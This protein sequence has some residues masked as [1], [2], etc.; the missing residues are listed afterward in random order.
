M[1]R[2]ILYTYVWNHFRPIV[3]LNENLYEYW[4]SSLGKNLVDSRNRLKLTHALNLVFIKRNYALL[5]LLDHL[6]FH[7]RSNSISD[8]SYVLQGFQT[9]HLVWNSHRW[10]TGLLT[11]CSFYKST[12]LWDSHLNIF[13]VM[14]SKTNIS[15]WMA[16]SFFS[17][18]LYNLHSECKYSVKC[19]CM[20]KYL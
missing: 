1:I 12:F 17:S 8:R 7:Q 13:M 2:V 9:N 6:Q 19:I 10:T 15:L 18:Q 14:D 5:L 11:N 20:S 4:Q 3:F 16:I